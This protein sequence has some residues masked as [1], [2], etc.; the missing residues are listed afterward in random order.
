MIG[1]LYIGNCYRFTVSGKEP[2]DGY[3]RKHGF[4]ALVVVHEGSRDIILWD[5]FNR[6]AYN[7]YYDLCGYGIHKLDSFTFA[8]MLEC[9][10]I[11]PEEGKVISYL[12]ANEL[13]TLYYQKGEK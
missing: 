10:N 11:D 8:L 6:P 2:I 5:T 7:C 1:R 13:T 4:N 9:L 3:L 12:N